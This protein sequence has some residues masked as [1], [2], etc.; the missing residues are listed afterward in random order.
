[1]TLTLQGAPTY[2]FTKFSKNCMKFKEFGT[3]GASKTLRCRSATGIGKKLLGPNLYPSVFIISEM[4]FAK[5]KMK[6]IKEN[7]TKLVVKIE[8]F[9]RLP[10]IGTELRFDVWSEWHIT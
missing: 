8:I 2:D 4:L 3:G 6:K 7:K 10:T 9:F 1:M 5:K